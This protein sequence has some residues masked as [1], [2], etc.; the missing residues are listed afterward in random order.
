MLA[1][2]AQATQDE[3]VSRLL[4]N[5][6]LS[7]DQKAGLIQDICSERLDDQGRNFIS[8]VADNKRLP[9]LPEISALFDRMKAEQEKSVDIQVTSA[10]K[11]TKEQQ[12]KLAQALGKKLDREINISSSIDKSLIGGLVIR[13]NDL[14][15]DGSV[16]GKLNKL[17]E[18]MS[19]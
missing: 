15:I 14:V 17:A 18:S 8:I 12:T 19:S 4:S 6:A 7:S 16:R 13:S 1:L 5:P 2:A 11:L 3:Q 9:V 10:F